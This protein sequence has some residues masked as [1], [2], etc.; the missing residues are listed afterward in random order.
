MNLNKRKSFTLFSVVILCTVLLTSIT[1]L[2][3][4]PSE[5][6]I[7]SSGAYPSG[8]HT[9]TVWA[10]GSGNY[11][12]KTAYGALSYT[13]TNAT[14]IFE[15]LTAIDDASILVKGG[16]YEI[17]NTII[18]TGDNVTVEGEGRGTVFYL[19]D[20]K[21]INMFNLTSI[22]GPT[23][24]NFAV[25][26]NQANQV[27]GGNYDLQNAVFFGNTNSSL[28]AV[29]NGV[30]ESLYIHDVIG[31]GVAVRGEYTRN[32]KVINNE[33]QNI[34]RSGIVVMLAQDVLVSENT[35][36]DVGSI[37]D[38]NNKWHG[39]YTYGDNHIISDNIVVRSDG[40][41]IETYGGYNVTLT[42]NVVTDSGRIGIYVT[43][44]GPADSHL[45]VD[46]NIIVNTGLNAVNPWGWKEGIKASGDGFVISN[47]QIYGSPTVG[48]YVD[49]SNYTVISGNLV[50]NSSG[51]GNGI[52]VYRADNSVITGNS[53]VFCT[54]NGFSITE[55]NYVMISGNTASNNLRGFVLTDSYYIA[56]TGNY[57]NDNGNYGFVEWSGIDYNSFVGCNAFNN[58]TGNIIVSGANTEVHSCFN[59]TS[60]VT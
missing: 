20:S 2:A 1:V 28:G 23:L 8:S 45:I 48:I 49:T 6:I 54:N 11:Y 4:I 38:I 27:W 16:T 36:Y 41:G 59:G 30:V 10:D 5:T 39:I 51:I 40:D 46:G 29:T 17:T 35:L 26:G 24:R 3:L 13:G 53:V 25:D 42:N 22:N 31:A 37:V 14:E 56:L 47:N 12:S 60:W 32:I 9:Y 34:P 7:I 15:S 57:A 43:A 50:K 21:S 58:P 52:N 19:A 55:S 18:P 44:S 33:I